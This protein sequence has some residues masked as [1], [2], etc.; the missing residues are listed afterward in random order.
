MRRNPDKQAR[1]M[2]FDCVSMT[3]MSRKT[4]IT[5][6][7]LYSRRDQPG[8]ITLD[9]LSEIVRVRHLT[10]EQLFDLVNER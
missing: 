5:R 2:L 1:E 7:T 10:A 9:E 3:E 4:V 8:K 6:K